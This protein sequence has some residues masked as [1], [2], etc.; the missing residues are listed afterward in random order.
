MPDDQ[1][2]FDYA[3][4]DE[5]D[6]G[7][8]DI[9]DIVGGGEDSTNEESEKM[10]LFEQMHEQAMAQLAQTGVVAQN[11]FTTVQK[12]VDFDYLENKRMVTLDEA[13]GVREVSPGP[14]AMKTGG[15]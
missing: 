10:P 2:N 14:Y 3:G 1:Y 4:S 8:L 15:A 7:N 13:I 9:P 11:N 5:P 12:V 6:D